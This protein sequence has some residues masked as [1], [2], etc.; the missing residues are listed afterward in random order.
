MKLS[1]AALS[2]TLLCAACGG[3]S[4]EPVSTGTATTPQ[5]ASAG[6]TIQINGAGATFPNPLYSKWF[7]EYNK[8][9]PEVRINYQSIGSGG[10]IQQILAQTVFFGATDSPM[11]EEQ[12]AS[13][14]GTIL[15]FPTVLGAV[16][17]VY[18][19]EGLSG[20]LKF[21][22]PVLADI[23]L[24]KIK[25]W[26]D[27]AIAKLNA[28]AKLPAT[29]ITVVHRSEGSGTTFIFVDFLGKASPEWQTKVGVKPSVNWPAGVGGKGNE[30]V[31]G[32]IK[33][34]PGSIGYVELIYALQNTISYGAV[35]N[36]AGE[37]V[38]ADV[39]SV[40][41]AAAGALANMP[42]DFRVSIT[43]APG[44]GAYPISSFTWMLMY[45][46]PKDLAQAKIM[47]DFMKWALGDGQK[48]AP[49]LGYASLPAGLIQQEM[50]Q[51]ARI[52]LQ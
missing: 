10:G 21:T 19:I 35:Q 6:S 41:A 12:L 7:S 33:Q 52:K 2:L 17:P 30:G 39:N 18:N 9:H 47:V 50:D 5:A 13:A 11:T 40:T 32:L 36:Q 42:K 4:S 34:T 49:P 44:Q 29:E 48:L 20:P 8:L 31:A 43:N 28:G 45:E 15:H 27:P 3:G 38:T 26:N 23:Y 37:F 14:K 16:V 51:L 22:G 1:V 24:G 46:T 25:R